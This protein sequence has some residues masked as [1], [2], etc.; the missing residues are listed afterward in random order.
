M[1]ITFKKI[2]LLLALFISIF[3][4]FT[5][6]KTSQ[7][8]ER[9]D[10]EEIELE[11]I[12]FKGIDENTIP[13]AAADLKLL[14]GGYKYGE[15]INYTYTVIGT[16]KKTSPEPVESF[17]EFSVI[18]IDENGKY[19]KTEKTDTRPGP[20]SPRNDRELFMHNS[21]YHFELEIHTFNSDK[22]PV[23][24]EFIDIK[25]LNKS[26]FILITL[27]DAKDHINKEY[28][29]DAKKII[30]LVLTHEPDNMEAKSLL[31]QIALLEEQEI[32]EDE[33]ET[34]EITLFEK[35]ED[36]T[37]NT[38]EELNSIPSS[39]YDWKQFL[40]DYEEWVDS[41]I[42]LLNKY[43]ENPLDMSIL[44]EY[45]EQMQKLVEWSEKADQVEIDLANDPNA[46]KEYLETLSRIILKLS[47]VS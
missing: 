5:S 45:L 3:I 18:L 41:Y 46:M 30:N 10:L 8:E 4:L 9:E 39:N 29:N 15:D 22:V 43:N 47:G 26:E 6:C 33:E 16:L 40:K 11:N 23:A 20:F 24:V 12:V 34:E 36:T 19:I 14:Q 28:Y 37:A 17:F 35:I 42:I 21:T 27:N 31:E 25:E 2:F 1:K 7:R 38:P 32:E 44:T 13:L